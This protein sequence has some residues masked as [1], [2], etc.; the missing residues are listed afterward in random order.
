[1][2]MLPGGNNQVPVDTLQL[3]DLEKLERRLDRARR[4]GRRLVNSMPEEDQDKYIMEMNDPATIR[5]GDQGM[6]NLEGLNLDAEI[7]VTKAP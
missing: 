4:D 1:M 6:K 3:E 7:I 5:R 2:H